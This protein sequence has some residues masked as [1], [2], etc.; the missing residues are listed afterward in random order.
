VLPCP[1]RPVN[2]YLPVA[3]TPIAWQVAGGFYLLSCRWYAGPLS[4]P[5]GWSRNLQF[6]QRKSPRLLPLR[7]G[8]LLSTASAILT[9]PPVAI[10]LSGGQP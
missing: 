10:A 7:P 4:S 5:G 8:L 6:G 9:P 1:W 2:R 3:R